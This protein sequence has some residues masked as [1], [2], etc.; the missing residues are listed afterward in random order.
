MS[1]TWW[2]RASAEQRLAQIDAALELGVEM[3]VLAA[4]LG[5]SRHSLVKFAYRH[6]RRLMGLRRT[7]ATTRTEKV[8][9]RRAM[10][11]DYFSGAPVDFWAA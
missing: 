6:G 5:T 8:K 10:R 2:D 4:Y 7:V 11:R 1:A 3:G 9:E